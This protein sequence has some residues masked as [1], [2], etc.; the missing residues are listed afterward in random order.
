[1]KRETRRAADGRIFLSVVVLLL[2]QGAI[3]ALAATT[4]DISFTPTSLSFKY[5]I[6]DPL[7]AA[8][9]LQIKST[10]SAF[11]VTVSTTVNRPAGSNWLSLS[12][13]T[14]TTS[15]SVK[16]YV[17][18]TGLAA[19]IYTATIDVVA[20]AAGNS[21]KSLPVT[22]EVANAAATLA[23]VPTALSFTYTTGTSAPSAKTITLSSSGVPLSATI[24]ISGA[25]IKASPSGSVTLVG[26]PAT[27]SVSADPTGLAPGSYTGKITFAS[28][29]ASNKSVVIAIALDVNAGAPTLNSTLWPAG[30][31]VNSPATTVT[32]TGTNFFSTTTALVNGSATG[33]STTYISPTTLLVTIAA[34]LL[35]GTDL[36]VSVST[37][38]PGGGT[39]SA[40]TFYVYPATPQI[41]AI[42]S[43]ASYDTTAISPGEIIAIYGLGLA[44]TTSV[45]QATNGAIPTAWPASGSQTFVT[46]D[47]TAAPLLYI[48]PSQVTCIVPYA[49]AAKIGQSV[50]VVVIYN[51]NSSPSKAINV[52]STHPAVFTL[53]AS[54]VGQAAVLNYNSNTGDY[55]V[56]NSTNTA[57]KNSVI[58]IFLTGFGVTSQSN[59]GDEALLV[60]GTVT[61]IGVVSVTIDGQTAAVQG[62]AV[63]VGSVP[64]VLQVNATV[65]SNGI[66][67]GNSIKLYVSVGGVQ[68]QDN[69][70]IAIK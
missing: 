6:G 35:T 47:G 21:P 27:V 52:A 63:P 51:G 31:V 5:T 61:P 24:S 66:S 67:T 58:S 60:T 26:L 30:T 44:G 42:A 34:T 59:P 55:T 53:N 10:G 3:P 64:G 37:P 54:G 69:V 1:M 56:N 19:G 39:S 23:A 50:P 9:S 65:P 8:Q 62:S 29:T 32:L 46:I 33:V 25:W 36:A 18:P 22:L 57:S 48:S 41:S 68:S 16:V 28:S 20:P 70:T 2:V 49:V 38:V 12:A 13:N 45:F 15:L 40:A 11:T 14:G 7:P 43:V 17:N 4:S